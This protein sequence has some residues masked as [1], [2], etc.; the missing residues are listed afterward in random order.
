[1]P[2]LGNV[3]LLGVLLAGIA[4]YFVGFMWFGVIFGDVW[5]NTNGFTED[6]FTDNNP[7][8]M[9]GGG[10]AI[11]LVIAFGLGWLMK[12]K[13]ITTLPTAVLMGLWV[14]LLIGFPL[15]AYGFVYSPEQ[16]P[17]NLLLDWGH[18]LVTFLVGTAVLSFFD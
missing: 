6:M 12:Q 14:A 5:M 15:L 11:P 8:I 13:G 7:L 9:W 10:I 1:M 3:N 18:T 17:V 2:R 16:N 4:M